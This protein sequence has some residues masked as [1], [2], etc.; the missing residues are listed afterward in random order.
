M[1]GISEFLAKFKIIPNPRDEKRKIAE[2]ISKTLGQ[3]ELIDEKS[4]EIKGFS[5]FIDVHPAIK[6]LIFQKKDEILQEINN[7]FVDKNFKNIL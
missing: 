6:N 4:L 2:I 1:K 3:E 5:V 7:I